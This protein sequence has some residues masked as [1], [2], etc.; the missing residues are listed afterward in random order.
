[1][2]RGYIH[3]VD[4]LFVDFEKL[5][6]LTHGYM[7]NKDSL[8]IYLAIGLGDNFTLFLVGIQIADFIGHATF[9]Y[10]AIRSLDKTEFID[11]SEGRQRVDQSNIRTFR[12]FD[13]TDTSV[14]RWMNISHFKSSSFSVQAPRTQS[15]QTTLM[16]KLRQWVNLIH[17]LRQL[18][19][20]E[21]V[22][23]YRCKCLWID[24]LLR[25]DR[26]NA[27]I[28][29]RHTFPYQTFR[30]GKTQATLVG[31]Q[32]TDRPNP[33]ASQVI[34]VIQV[35][36]TTFKFYQILSRHHHIVALQS[37]L[38]DIDVHLQFLVD[39]IATNSAQVVAFR[40]EKQ[41]LQQGFSICS[42][43]RFTGA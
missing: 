6:A 37:S 5:A 17:K 36:L 32:L 11:T 29:Q 7:A 23:Y 18:A 4:F 25:S 34:N 31:Q 13:R 39:L 24:Q 1:M 26:V 20:R 15:R 22:A 8:I 28:V 10:Y 30:A 43:G 41:T 12:R 16:S 38:L 21:K 42:C 27:L 35:S 33:S 2:L 3:E 19:T 9:F 14:V 40:I